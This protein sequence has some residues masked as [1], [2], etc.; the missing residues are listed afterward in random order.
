[1]ESQLSK[2]DRNFKEFLDRF[3]NEGLLQLFITNYLYELVQY[4]LHSRSDGEIDTSIEYYL[5]FKGIRY[6]AEEIDQFEAELWKDC[7]E[8][9]KKV[10]LQLKKLDLIKKIAHEPLSHPETADIVINELER[11]LKEFVSD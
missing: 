7:G 11:V 1:M 5:N 3:G 6:K 2:A 4:F 8:R 9:A 10:V